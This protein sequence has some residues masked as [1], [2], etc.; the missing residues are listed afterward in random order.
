V[1]ESVVSS[2]D[3]VVILAFVE[4]GFVLKRELYELVAT[5]NRHTHTVS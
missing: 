3:A 4:D 2:T 1:E 5:F